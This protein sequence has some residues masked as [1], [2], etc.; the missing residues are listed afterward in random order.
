MKGEANCK[1]LN[2]SLHPDCRLKVIPV[3]SKQRRGA[4]RQL[5]ILTRNNSNRS[6]TLHSAIIISSNIF[7]NVIFGSI[8]LCLF[9]TGP[10]QRHCLWKLAQQMQHNWFPAILHWT[11][12][13]SSQKC[14][15][16]IRHGTLPLTV[17]QA[18][19]LYCKTVPSN[20]HKALFSLLKA[21]LCPTALWVFINSTF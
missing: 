15:V 5:W 11:R 9:I 16:R 17:S 10:V 20:C 12:Q 1:Q 6:V 13:L 7:F 19:V 8:C 3:Y 4:Q 2:I 14:V 18:L 21:L